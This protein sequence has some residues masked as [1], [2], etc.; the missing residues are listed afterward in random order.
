MFCRYIVFINSYYYLNTMIFFMVNCHSTLLS[1][2]CWQQMS[3]HKTY[4]RS[5]YT[6]FSFSYSISI[7]FSTQVVYASQFCS[8]CQAY[9]SQH[10]FPLWHK[11]STVAILSSLSILLCYLHLFFIVRPS[12]FTHY[13]YIILLILQQYAIPWLYSFSIFLVFNSLRSLRI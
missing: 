4:N 1:I 2:R 10:Y 7:V 11:K 8:L 5:L 6:N 9:W 3:V 13:Q 12:H